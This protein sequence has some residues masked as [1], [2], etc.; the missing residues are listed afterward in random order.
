MKLQAGVQEALV[1]LLCFDQESCSEIC[2][3]LEP[4]HFDPV[5]REVAEGAMDFYHRFHTCPGEHTL[6]IIQGL[7]TK[8]SALADAYG[9]LYDSILTLHEELQP[10][11]VMGRAKEFAHFQTLR[12][13]IEEA[14]RNLER[15]DSEGL[16]A[17]EAALSTALKTQTNTFDSGTEW[18]VDMAKTMAYLEDPEEVFPTGITSLDRAG[19]G[20]TR[21]RLMMF[22][23]ISGRGKS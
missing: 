1:A 18:G 9:Q 21:G 20:P 6:D 4:A 10:A 19:V 7:Q 12:D 11:Y 14:L 3:F 2:T 15:D 23:A 8:Q 22:N 16:L 13:G 17:A 5:Y